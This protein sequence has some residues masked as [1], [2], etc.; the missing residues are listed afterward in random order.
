MSQANVEQF[1]QQVAQD[2][3]LQEQLKSTTATEDFQTKMV[4]LGKQ[5]GLSFAENDVASYMKTQATQTIGRSPNEKLTE[6]ELETVAGGLTPA[7]IGAANLTFAI[8]RYT[9]S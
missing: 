2:A 6:E 9:K 5:K 7:T 4:D 3:A 1:I 8:Y